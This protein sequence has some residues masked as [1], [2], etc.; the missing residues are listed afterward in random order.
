MNKPLFLS[1]TLCLCLA[2]CS[3]VKKAAADT[4]PKYEI[5]DQ[6]LYN[7]IVA[8]DKT[9][10]DAYNTCDLDKQA[11]IYADDIEFYHDLSGLSTSKQDILDGTKKNI[12]GKVTRELVAGTIEVYPI[13]NYGAVEI[14]YHKF[15]NNQEPNA[16][17]H[18]SKF[19]IM[20]H[21]SNN[22]WKINKVVSLH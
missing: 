11:T 8:M 7:Q 17:S 2:S 12:C 5:K 13:K 21:F 19:I 9:F 15:H 16:V 14:G 18:P 10:F 1:L 3:S 22:E 4:Q 6:E 20:W